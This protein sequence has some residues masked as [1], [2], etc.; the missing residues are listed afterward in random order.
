M[1]FD[2]NDF[3]KSLKKT[4]AVNR[5]LLEEIV[6]SAPKMEVLTGSEEWDNYLTYLQ[7]A[8]DMTIGQLEY[9][10]NLMLDPNSWDNESLMKTKMNLLRLRE[11][12]EVL[13]FVMQMP[14]ELIETGEIAKNQ[15]LESQEVSD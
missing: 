5:P 10:N 1:T 4:P 8:L 2:R 11:K 15:L 6:R 9:T 14:K 3:E 12:K 7:T 13:E